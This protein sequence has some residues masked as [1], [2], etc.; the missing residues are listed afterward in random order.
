LAVYERF[1]LTGPRAVLARDVHATGS[2]LRRLAASA[3]S[4]AHGPTSNAALGSGIFPLR[5]H[6]DAGVRVALGTDVGGGTGLG[7]LKEALHAYLTQR[8]MKDGVTLGA[9]H[10]LY[11]ATRAGAEALALADEVGDFEPGKSADFVLIRAPGRSEL[12]GV[13]HRSESLEQ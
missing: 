10:L 13:L 12:A 3:T 6:L 9:A 8:P 7:M 11:L 1:E 5:R 4:I 2:E